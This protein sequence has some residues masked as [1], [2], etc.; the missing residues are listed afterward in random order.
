[1]S[2]HDPQ[3]GSPV[4]ATPAA[5]LRVAIVSTPRSGNTWLWHLLTTAYEIPGIAVHNPFD[6][7]WENLPRDCVL[8]VHWRLIP[9]F[10][11]KLQ[12]HGFRLVVMGRHPL[13]VLISILHFS[14]HD[15]STAR[16]LE[17][18]DGTERPIFGAMPRSTA[19]RDYAIG[20]RAAA[21]LSVSSEWWNV[22]SAIR[23][24]YEDLNA[25]PARELS[26]VVAALGR[27]T[28]RSIAAA[29]EATTIPKLRAR[30]Q[31][32]HYFWKGK[33]SLWRSL[34]TAR[35]LE[36][37][38][39]ALK[40]YLQTLGYE[41]IPDADLDEHQADANWLKLVWSELAEDI[42]KLAR[43]RI[44]EK[45]LVDARARGQE[46]E[47]ELAEVRPQLEVS[48]RDLACTQDRLAETHLAYDQAQR[49]LYTATQLLK[50]CRQDLAAMEESRQWALA[51]L[52][53]VNER[54]A[55]YAEAGPLGLSVAVRLTRLARRY[56]W[57]IALLKG[58][59]PK[60]SEAA[61]ATSRGKAPS[62]WRRLAGSLTSFWLT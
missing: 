20:R 38:A 4:D 12:E 3:A 61:A 33:T 43:L 55:P 13:D 28:T 48:R 34:L 39:E 29:I 30:W 25:D 11:A 32:N 14:M 58:N 40:P 23:V 31:N 50:C 62:A 21:L 47:R 54:F 15:A 51:E 2:T 22:A 45:S 46:M 52:A 35:D 59:Y 26:R 6:A 24:R 27:E 9:S 8:Q 60:K 36:P 5:P 7:D 17:G 37:I 53:K 56:P 41:C 10:T 16:W 42:H 57:L 18:E 44:A 19:F 49:D 1:M